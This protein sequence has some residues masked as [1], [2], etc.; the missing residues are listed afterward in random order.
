MRLELDSGLGRDPEPIH[1]EQPKLS[2]GVL[3]LRLVAP[4]LRLVRLVALLLGRSDPPGGP[5]VDLPVLEVPVDLA[6]LLRRADLL[7]V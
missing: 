4:G 6:R 1:L 2:P 5:D 3:E 7:M